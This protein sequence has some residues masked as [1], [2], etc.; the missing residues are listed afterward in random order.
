MSARLQPAGF[1]IAAMLVSLLLTA[2]GGGGGDSTDPSAPRISRLEYSP[3]AVYASDATIEIGGSFDFSDPDGDV[4]SLTFSLIDAAGVTL[5]SETLA[6]T[7]AAGLT[8]GRLAGSVSAVADTPGNY[9]IAL[10]VTDSG[11]QRSNTLSGDFRVARFPWT[12]RTAPSVRRQYAAVAALAGKLYLIGGQ[13]TDAGVV[14]GPATGAVEVY[15]PRTDS[16]S[17]AAPL[18]T[19]RMGLVAAVVN[20]KLYA[21]GGQTDGFSTSVTGVVEIFDPATGN[22]SP[23]PPMRVPRSFAAGAALAV[24][25]AGF[26]EP[27][28]FVA[29]G[30]VGDV[31]ALADFD[32]YDPV[33]NLWGALPFM[34]T[35]R[36][37]LAAAAAGGRFLAVGGYSGLVNQW[38]ATVE[39]YD[40]VTGAWQSR[41]PM[42]NA[43]SGLVAAVVGNRLLAAGGE[44][45]ER[46]LSVLEG[47]DLPAD[48]GAALAWKTRTASPVAF[49]RAAAAVVDAKVY[50]LADGLTLEYD[51]SQEIVN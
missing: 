15:D 39:S 16:W 43:R 51:P 20:G 29:G 11:G 5:D 27:R 50:V 45:V 17:S 48:P 3:Q 33:D 7:D 44:N 38:V 4:A 9:R 40:P 26:L 21:I 19:A 46:A 28:I 31:D 13:R 12:T 42:A 34:P 32:A 24:N 41:T 30:R 25:V 18:P 23:G 1:A 47:V 37:E 10:F 22:W 49:T 8:S 35:P 14:P 36:R 6:I 2:C